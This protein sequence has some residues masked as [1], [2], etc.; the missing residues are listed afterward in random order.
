MGIYLIEKKIDADVI[1]VGKEIIILVLGVVT[2]N[3]S[4]FFRIIRRGY[5]NVLIFRVSF[6]NLPN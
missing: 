6:Q 5:V 2:F 1:N 3:S 4:E